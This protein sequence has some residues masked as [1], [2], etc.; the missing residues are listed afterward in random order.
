M[1]VTVHHDA[2]K[3]RFVADFEGQRCVCDYRLF[4][5]DGEVML[6]NTYV[7]P[8]LR[9]HGVAAELVA[10]ALAWAAQQGLKVVPACSYVRSYMRRHPA[11]QGLLAA[12]D[13]L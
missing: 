6:T 1:T 13:S 10:A 9:G 3:Q 2:A 4:E 7:P 5:H 11:T 8:A 12:G